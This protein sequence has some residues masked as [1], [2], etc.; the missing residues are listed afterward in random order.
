MGDLVCCKL[1]RTLFCLTQIG[2][3]GDIVYH[4]VVLVLY[5]KTVN[6]FHISLCYNAEDIFMF[7]HHKVQERIAVSYKTLST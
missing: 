7:I 1:V 6:R 3:C 5:I 4:S 2:E